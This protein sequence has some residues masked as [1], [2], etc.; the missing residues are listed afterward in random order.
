MRLAPGRQG[1]QV[2]RHND[3]VAGPL[4]PTST[5]EPPSSSLFPL[6]SSYHPHRPQNR[7]PTPTTMLFAILLFLPILLLQHVAYGEHAICD[8]QPDPNP[9]RTGLAPHCR[10]DFAFDKGSTTKG[11]SVLRTR[12]RISADRDLRPHFRS[13][14][15]RS[16][17]AESCHLGLSTSWHRRIR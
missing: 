17:K 14:Q 2:S 8:W 6:I 9:N 12:A 7:I 1:G 15:M 16:L 13:V 10:A 5:R 11:N 4:D 3:D